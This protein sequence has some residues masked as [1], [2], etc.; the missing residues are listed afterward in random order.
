MEQSNVILEVSIRAGKNTRIV[1]NT[2]LPIT[3]ED[4]ATKNISKQKIDTCAQ[5]ASDAITEIMNGMAMNDATAEY[6]VT[7][8]A[9]K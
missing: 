7:E 8:E 6:T 2:T 4:I 3:V 9:I 5:Y 1:S